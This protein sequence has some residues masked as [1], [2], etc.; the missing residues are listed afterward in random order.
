MSIRFQR[1]FIILFS[2]VLLTGAALLILKNSKQNLVFFYTPSEF[3]VSEKKIDQKIRIGGFVKKNS[4]KKE[5]NN[6]YNFEI[7]D[8]DNS[9]YIKYQG[10]LPNLFREEQGIVIE[11]K[12]LNENTIRASR[13]FAKH[14]ENYM[15]A[16]IKK[17]L[18]NKNLWKKEYDS[19]LPDFK[20]ES[21]FNEKEF[22]SSNN[23]K[24]EFIIIN[25][26]ASWCAPCKLEHSLFFILKEKF[27]EAHLM[28]ISFKDSKEDTLKY[29]NEFG[30]PF[31]KILT[32]PDGTISI[33]LGAYGV[34][35]TFLVNSE[36]KIVRKYIGPLKTDDV[37]E[38]IKI[39]K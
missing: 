9:I 27:P 34:P 39:A 20:I 5:K 3:F 8:N 1:L 4:V 24:N 36:S 19:I 15:P 16:S 22:I 29:L 37:L 7:T 18:E 13:V 25:F 32:D 28:G 38:I 14:D 33:A 10:I 26:F 35:E 31:V 12:I 21:I 17:E 30:N 23:I 2:L 11:G 6:L